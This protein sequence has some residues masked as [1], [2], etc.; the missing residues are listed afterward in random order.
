MTNTFQNSWGD[1][2]KK[3]TNEGVKYVAESIRQ[4]QKLTH[5]KLNFELIRK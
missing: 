5:L 4:L 2:N 3:I 1:M